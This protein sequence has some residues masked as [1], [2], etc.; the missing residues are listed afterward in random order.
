MQ[1]AVASTYPV[2]SH[3]KLSAETQLRV[4]ATQL[5]AK[6]NPVKMIRAYCTMQLIVKSL[7]LN[8][9]YYLSRQ[10]YN[11]VTHHVS[12]IEDSGGMDSTNYCKKKK[13]GKWDRTVL[14]RSAP[15]ARARPPAHIAHISHRAPRP[16]AGR[17][18]LPGNLVVPPANKH[19]NA[20]IV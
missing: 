10:V 15:F 5:A 12:H 3:R 18:L 20:D 13:A 1:G 2:P 9:C 8:P 14:G 17:G 7:Q 4:I 6:F 11:D 19:L 16:T